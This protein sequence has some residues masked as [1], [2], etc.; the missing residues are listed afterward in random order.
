M[1]IIFSINGGIGKC[2]MAT[3]V[4]EAIKKKYP[5][6]N[7]IVVSGYPD[8]FL[9]NPNIHRT[10]EFGRLSYFYEE[11]VEGKDLKV[12]ANDPYLT[13][14]HIKQNEH[15]IKTWCE[16]FDLHYKGEQPQIYLTPRE[17]KYFSSMFISEKPIF[18]IQA[19]GGAG[20]E[21]KYSWARDLPYDLVQQIIDELKNDYTVLNISRDDQAKY[22]DCQPIQ[23][24]FRQLCVLISLSAKRL[25]ID[26][27]A[28]HVAASFN[29]PSV[30]CWVANK[31][32]VFGYDVHTN[33]SSNPFTIKPELRNSFLH[34]FNIQGDLM[35][36][37]YKSEGEVF[38]KEIIVSAIK[39]EIP[40]A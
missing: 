23:A 14:S 8:V 35:E 40:S 34:K 5:K 29:L 11:Y 18:L 36:F 3:A 13:T 24:T 1:N 25:F 17:I 7:L 9:N 33:I 22:R 10:Y 39:G 19:N 30:V 20:S 38:S 28:Q 2:V 21:L 31:P 26:S 12:F 15:L 4:C 37:P 32:E 6:S 16:M 27:F